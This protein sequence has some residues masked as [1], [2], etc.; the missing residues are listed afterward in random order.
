MTSPI[1]PKGAA[2]PA[3]GSRWW[4]T[5]TQRYVLV[6]ARPPSEQ[7]DELTVVPLTG[8]YERR[9]TVRRGDLLR[10]DLGP[11]GRG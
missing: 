11:E 9:R 1:T 2:R 5:P 10:E 4:H 3:V 7:D 8:E 6:C